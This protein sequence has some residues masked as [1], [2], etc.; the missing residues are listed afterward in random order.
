MTAYYNEFDPF[1]AAWLRNLIAAGHIAP[2][3]VDERSIEDVSPDDLRPYTQCHFFA[4]IGVWSYALRRAGWDD[5]RPVW[6]GS[7]PCQPFSAAGKGGGFADERH[8]WPAFFHL[9]EQCDPAIVIGEQVASKDGLAWLDLVRSDLEG[10]GRAFAAADLCAA[11]VGAPHIRQRTFWMAHAQGAGRTDGASFQRS[12]G[13]ISSAPEPLIGVRHRCAVDGMAHAAHVG[14]REGG[15]HSGGVRRGDSPQ[16]R[17]AG[18]VS[19]SAVIGLVD[20]ERARLEGQRGGP[21]GAGGRDAAPRPV[22]AAGE[23]GGV[24]DSASEGR[25]GGERGAISGAA[26]G[27][28]SASSDEG[29][30]DAATDTGEDGGTGPTNGFWRD[31]DWLYCRDGK[32]R[33]VESLFQSLA[34]GFAGGMGR[35]RDDD[36]ASLEAEVLSYAKAFSTDPGQDVRNLWHDLPASVSLQRA[37]GGQHGVHEAEVLFA[38]LCQLAGQG[39][40]LAQGIALPRPQEPLSDLRMLWRRQAATR[41]SYQRELGGQHPGEPTDAMYFLSSILARHA[42]AAWGDAIRANAAARSPLASGAVNRVGRLRG[43]GNAI[44]APVAETFIRAVIEARRGAAL[45]T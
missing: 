37:L 31:A 7:C 8:L 35:L 11:G 19:G 44:V 38:F 15:T 26:S 45:L 3:D 28:P 6:T 39:W 21:S 2:G 17:T 30:G 4:G 43:Y 14:R 40:N 22:A 1:A 27:H 36:I 16:G 42:Q 24:G 18:L 20:G 10:T 32:W 13:S 34:N 9:I 33:P 41:S 5:D 29:H 25:H 23:L 12:R